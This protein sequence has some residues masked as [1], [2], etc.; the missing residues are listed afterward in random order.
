MCLYLSY[1]IPSMFLYM[2][3]ATFE[4]EQ[5]VCMLYFSFY[6]VPVSGHFSLMLSQHGTLY[7]TVTNVPLFEVK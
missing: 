6:W 1:M 3:Y 2:Y 4:Y 5:C 7:Y